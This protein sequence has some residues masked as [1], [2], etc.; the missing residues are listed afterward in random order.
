MVIFLT[1]KTLNFGAAAAYNEIQGIKNDLIL[2]RLI[3][4]FM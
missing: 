1:S 2:T 4:G 3:L